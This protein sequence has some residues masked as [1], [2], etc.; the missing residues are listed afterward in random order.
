MTALTVDPAPWS[1]VLAAGALVVLLVVLLG[2]YV[3]TWRW[4]P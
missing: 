2:V 3:G 1:Y 4:K